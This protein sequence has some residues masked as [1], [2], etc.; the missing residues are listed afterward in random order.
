MQIGILVLNGPNIARSG[1]LS[2]QIKMVNPAHS[3]SSKKYIFFARGQL[4]VEQTYI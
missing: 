1:E 2:T 4:E 3:I